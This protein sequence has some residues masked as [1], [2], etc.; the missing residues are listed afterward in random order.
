MNRATRVVLIALGVI[1]PLAP[2]AALHAAD[3][4]LVDQGVAPAPIVVFKDAPTRTRDAAVTLADYIE[5]ISGVRPEVVDGQPNPLPQ[6]AIW[7]GFQPAMKTLFPKIDF[8]FQH[9]EE[10]LI[11]AN[12]KHLV[13]AGRD[14]WDPAHTEAKGRLAMKTGM[15]QEY[16]TA[17]AVYTFI[18]DKLGVR[19]LWPGEE[20]VP[21]RGRIAIAPCE[22][23]YHPQIRARS[24]IF[25]KLSLGD[26]KEGPDE[27][28]ARFQRVQLD[29]LELLGGHAFGHWWDKYHEQHPEYF[30]LQPDGTRSPHPTPNNTKLCDSNPAVWRQW[31]AEVEEQLQAD[32]TRRVFNVSPND[33]YDYGHCVCAECL[34]KDHPDGEKFT[35]RWKGKSEER[36][37][38]SDRQVTFANTLARLLKQRFPDR[39]LFVQLHAYGYSRPA[40]RVAAP[41]DNVIISSVANFH[42]RGDGVGDGRTKAMQQHADWAKKAQLLMWRPNLGSPVGQQWGMP[43]VSFQQTAE[44]FRFV[45]ERRCI[46]LFFDMLWFHWS[47][48]G[49]YYY[50]LAQ[51]AWNP[52]ADG[53]TI[54]DDYHRR[55]FGPGA[56]EMKAYWELLEQ[57]RMDF[58]KESPNRYRAYD[59]PQKYT[60]ELLAKAQT[61]LDAA[62][63]K[64]SGADAKYTRR[65][66]FMRCGFD[67]TKLVVDTRAWMQR[68]EA[69]KGKDEQAKARVLANWD[70]VEKMKKTFPEFAVNWQA[71]FRAGGE[72]KRVMGLHPDHPL[73]GRVKREKEIRNVE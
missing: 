23:R 26:N 45:A 3:L 62:A 27:L 64:A 19:W 4:V 29:S 25:V 14:R 38:L 69:G 16:G 68:F 72:G 36:P 35:W 44:D 54:M 1:L 56:A 59:I 9:P 30:A 73:S 20:D 65:V 8:E 67:Y 70:A 6:R 42:L 5:R 7:V 40:P 41:D 11:A 10:T 57:T 71:V 43:D 66:A 63:A 34:A 33:G 60:P 55:A 52:Y 37:A 24:G 22:V 17:N 39:Q 28:W 31:L 15:Q 53:Q 46:G 61:L 21:K 12:E 50:L 18:Q 48:Q 51:L 13:I 32:P 49:P 2:R 47:T 58:V